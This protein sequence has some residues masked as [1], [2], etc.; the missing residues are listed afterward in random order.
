MTLS[1]QLQAAP[2]NRAAEC[3]P[4]VKYPSSW[5]GLCFPHAVLGRV[6]LHL[7]C[8]VGSPFSKYF[9]DFSGISL[10]LPQLLAGTSSHPSCFSLA[11]RWCQCSPQKRV[12][13]PLHCWPLCSAGSS[14]SEVSSAFFPRTERFPNRMLAV[15]EGIC[16]FAVFFYF[17]AVSQA[18]F[19]VLVDHQWSVSHQ[20]GESEAENI[21]NDSVSHNPILFMPELMS[22][23]ITN[24]KT[25]HPAPRLWTVMLLAWRNIPLWWGGREHGSR[26]EATISSRGFSSP[27]LQQ[28]NM[29]L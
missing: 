17:S 12:P 2:E 25:P 10:W 6:M 22:I 28:E 29:S 26:A 3:D 5:D 15:Q 21:I 8:W 4:G 1:H 13:W 27:Y 14:G 16:G 24:S 9:L 23:S 11:F 7:P 20:L 18:V 19:W